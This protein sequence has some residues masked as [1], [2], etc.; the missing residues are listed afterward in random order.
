MLHKID[1][2]KF[3]TMHRTCH[4]NLCNVS[5]G[6][7]MYNRL[8]IFWGIIMYRLSVSNNGLF[9]FEFVFN[10]YFPSLF[11]GGGGGVLVGFLLL[12]F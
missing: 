12:P 5:T 4:C 3:L 1:L 8:L 6:N 7:I 11:F 2:Q 10:K 9:H